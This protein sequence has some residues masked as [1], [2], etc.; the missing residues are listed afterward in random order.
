MD[1]FIPRSSFILNENHDLIVR[2]ILMK[3]LAHVLKII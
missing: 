2:E 3:D 1:V